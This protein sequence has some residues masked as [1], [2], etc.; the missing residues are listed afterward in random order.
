MS[1]STSTNGS[2]LFLQKRREKGN[3]GRKFFPE[4]KP[5][6][7]LMSRCLRRN[8]LLDSGKEKLRQSHLRGWF[9]LLWVVGR[10]RSPRSSP[11]TLVWSAAAATKRTEGWA[12]PALLSLIATSCSLKHWSKRTRPSIKLEVVNRILGSMDSLVRKVLTGEDLLEAIS[13]D[14]IDSLNRAKFCKILLIVWK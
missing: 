8:L 2:A 5:E 12:R 7:P 1:R 14:G 6:G 13:P 3:S 10:G 9:S 4:K 11:A